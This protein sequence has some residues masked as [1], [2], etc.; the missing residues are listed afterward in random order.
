MGEPFYAAGLRF[1]CR[2]CSRCCRHEPG[3]VFLTGD[4]LERLA[5][6]LALPPAEV[7]ARFCRTVRVGAFRRVSLR[8]TRRYDCILWAR[9]GCRVYERRPLQC[10][11]F[12][13]WAANLGSAEDWEQ[14]KPAC[15]GVGGGGLH[16]AEEIR[17][18]LERSRNGRYL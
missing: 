12:P 6:G 18:W 11:S 17:D 2:R 9:D 14:L 7:L 15:P 10:R 8:E 5:A 16:P 4:D 3:Y 1:E 13:F